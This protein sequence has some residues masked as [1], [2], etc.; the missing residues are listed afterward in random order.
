[1]ATIAL[2]KSKVNYMPDLI[3]DF[4]NSVVNLKSDF[5]N[6]KNQSLK[7]NKNICNLDDIVN[8]ISSTTLTW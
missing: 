4:K 1:M 8:T 3:S 2:Y 7:V 5:T 6:F